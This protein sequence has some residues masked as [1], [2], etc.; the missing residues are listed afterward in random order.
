MKSQK[1][2]NPT[3]VIDSGMQKTTIH[4]PRT[5]ATHKEP[6]D[7]SDEWLLA[8]GVFDL[9]IFTIVVLNYKS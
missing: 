8:A 3:F 7:R 1:R 5:V 9:P 2:G 6:T 4:S